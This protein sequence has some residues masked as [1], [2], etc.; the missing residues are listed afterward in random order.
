MRPEEHDGFLLVTS[1]TFVKE[2]AH[3]GLFKKGGG[4]LEVMA[5]VLEGKSSRQKKLS[6]IED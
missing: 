1:R 4:S 6:E 2:V 5:L 3:K